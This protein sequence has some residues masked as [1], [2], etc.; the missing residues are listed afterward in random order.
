M[1]GQDLKVAMIG[2]KDVIDG[3]LRGPYSPSLRGIL[4]ANADHSEGENARDF[5]VSGY[6]LT[7]GVLDITSAILAAAID[8]TDEGAKA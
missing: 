3:L 6:D 4:E 5:L 7:H 1:K 8:Q 2:L